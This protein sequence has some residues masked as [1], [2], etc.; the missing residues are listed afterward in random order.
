MYQFST[1][2]DLIKN[3]LKDNN[4]SWRVRIFY[5]YMSI[6][7]YK[8]PQCL[9]MVFGRPT[10]VIPTGYAFKTF[11]KVLFATG[12]KYLWDRGDRLSCHIGRKAS[13]WSPNRGHKCLWRQWWCRNHSKR[14]F[15]GHAGNL[16]NPALNTRKVEGTEKWGSR[17]D[18]RLARI[19]RSSYSWFQGT[20]WSVFVRCIGPDLLLCVIDDILCNATHEQVCDSFVAMGGHSDHW[21]FQSFG[22]V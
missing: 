5:S 13:F 17:G 21:I 12:F 22:K 3:I 15:Y 19:I 18:M 2:P 16:N 8:V 14:C 4:H 11:S 10:L 7:F 20:G 6:F 9:F 1:I